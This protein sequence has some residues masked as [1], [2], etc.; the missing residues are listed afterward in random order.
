M[1]KKA[2]IVPIDLA[3]AVSYTTLNFNIPVKLNNQ[4]NANQAVDIKLKGYSVDAIVSKKLKFFTPCA[5]VGYNT[6]KSELKAKGSY[7]FDV[8]VTPLTP[9]G[10]KTYVDPINIKQTDV[11]GMKASLGFQLNLAFFRIYSSYTL[12]KYSYFNAGIG[13]GIGK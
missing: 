12:S 3:V 5:S 10:K 7:D 1:G 2:D 4:A 11:E 13:F 8:A 9:T 6:S